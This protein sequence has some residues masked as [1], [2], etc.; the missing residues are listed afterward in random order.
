MK[1]K[2]NGCA[3]K[4]ITM[5]TVQDQWT[6]QHHF[7]SLSHICLCFSLSQSPVLQS[8]PPNLHS[9]TLW[10][11]PT[12]SAACWVSSPAPRAR[13]TM[14]TVRL[15]SNERDTTLRANLCCHGVIFSFPKWCGTR[16][17]ADTTGRLF[18]SSSAIQNV[19][20]KGCMLC[21]DSCKCESSDIL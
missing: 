16:E 18:H 3:F 21:L 9:R 19:L 15:R 11:P 13:G 17:K 4:L 10:A 8:L 20:P 6:V 14:M 5:W 12:P 2:V 7:Q 1:K